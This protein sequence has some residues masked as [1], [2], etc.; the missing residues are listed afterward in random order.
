MKKNAEMSGDILSGQLKKNR[1]IL[2]IHKMTVYSGKM[3]R[4]SIHMGGA[5]VI[6]DRRVGE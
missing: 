1:G 3:H 4:K 2:N 6:I 5:A